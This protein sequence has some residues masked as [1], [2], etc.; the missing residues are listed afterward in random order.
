MFAKDIII[1]EKKSVLN[2]KARFTVPLFSGREV[3]EELLFAYS[4]ENDCIEIYSYTRYLE[5]VKNVAESKDLDYI[6]EHANTIPAMQ[7]LLERT[8][9]KSNVDDQGRITVSM[10][11][12]ERYGFTLNSDIYIIGRVDH[13]EIYPN[14]EAYTQ[15]LLRRKLLRKDSGLKRG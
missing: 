13:L 9:F 5:M 10:D 12:L 7:E 15:M 11:S 2:D 6:I 3:G 14:K 8:L 4:Y 1:G